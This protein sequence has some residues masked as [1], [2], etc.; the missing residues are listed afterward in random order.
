MEG[1]LVMFAW[2]INLSVNLLPH[3]WSPDHCFAAV[4][5]GLG[6]I[7]HANVHRTTPSRKKFHCPSISS[8]AVSTTP[9]PPQWRAVEQKYRTLAWQLSCQPPAIFG[10]LNCSEQ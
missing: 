8:L 9:Y 4:P 1:V 3:Y 6:F 10:N 5:V 7:R 2:I